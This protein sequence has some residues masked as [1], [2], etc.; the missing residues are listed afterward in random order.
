MISVNRKS[1]EKNLIFM[2]EG[3]NCLVVV[4]VVVFVFLW[5]DWELGNEMVVGALYEL[6][7]Q[8]Q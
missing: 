2:I 4:V 8:Q 1:A 3:P 5:S 6:L 7:L